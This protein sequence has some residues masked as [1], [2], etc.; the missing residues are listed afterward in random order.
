MP[1]LNE[2]LEKALEN[3][4]P[5]ERIDEGYTSNEL[6]RINPKAETVNILVTDY[7][8]NKTKNLGLNDKEAITAFKKFIE[9]RMKNIK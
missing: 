7:D 4:K 2:F 9:A 1:T 3:Y 8:G 5:E 6:K